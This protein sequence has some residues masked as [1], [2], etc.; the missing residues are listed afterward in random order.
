[1]AKESK[2]V[3]DARELRETYEPVYGEMDV[4]QIKDAVL[5]LLDEIEDLSDDRQAHMDSMKEVIDNRKD[6]LKYCRERR[7]FLR[8][9]GLTLTATELLD[10]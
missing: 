5:S 6:A 2:E 3:K 1:M 10:A 9:E 8:T 4:S 7:H